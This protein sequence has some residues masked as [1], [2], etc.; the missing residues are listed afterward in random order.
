MVNQGKT[1][2]PEQNTLVGESTRIHGTLAGSG[3]IVIHGRIEG[4]LRTT[5][6]AFVETSAT[7][8]ANIIAASVT[9]RGVVVGNIIATQSVQLTAE[10]RVVGDICTPRFSMAEGALYGGHVETD[11]TV[12][13]ESLDSIGEAASPQQAQAAKISPASQMRPSSQTQTAPQAQRRTAIM[14]PRTAI[15]APPPAPARV[16]FKPVEVRSVKAAER[17]PPPPPP[18]PPAPFQTKLLREEELFPG[19]TQPM[20]QESADEAT[21][22]PAMIGKRRSS[23]KSRK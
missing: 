17:V 15:P 23:L 7:L 20:S 6:S 14:G 18:A 1:E 11:E 13:R 8:Q 2:I 3:D 19:M 12:V 5:G 22:A 4:E 9:V 21:P 16:T 10:G